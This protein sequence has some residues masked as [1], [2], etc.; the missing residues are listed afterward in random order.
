MNGSLIGMEVR[1]RRYATPFEWL[2]GVVKNVGRE[3][4]GRT[5]YEIQPD[6]PIG[7]YTGTVTRFGPGLI[8]SIEDCWP[9]TQGPL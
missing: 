3:Q 2:T 8:E 1:F 7:E 9:K 4:N 5:K 6:E